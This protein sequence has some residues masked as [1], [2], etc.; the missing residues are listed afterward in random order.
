MSLLDHRLVVV[1]GKGGVGRTTLTAALA[2][3]AARAGKRTVAVELSGQRALARRLGCADGTFE[4]QRIKPRLGVMSLSPGTCLTDFGRRKLRLGGLA[5]WLFES[6]WMTGFVEAVPGLHDVVQLG[7]IEN[8]IREP[9]PGDDEVDLV[10]LDAPATGHGLTLLQS[11]RSMRQITRVGPF[12]DLAAII[13][14]FLADRTETASLLTTLPE[15]L[16]VNESLDLLEALDAEGALPS[17]VWVNRVLPPLLPGGLD[18]ERLLHTLSA[19]TTPTHEVLA[20][21]AGD[22]TRT[23]TR[24]RTAVAQLREALSARASAPTVHLLPEIRGS[25][26]GVEPLEPLVDAFLGQLD[27]GGAP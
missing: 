16:P 25:E 13:E 1:Q 26:Q 14:D 24:Q 6:R 27:V 2:L 23:R 19:G 20:A 3:A 4:A 15:L 22:H 12:H 17:S 11:A 18:Q 9:L 5:K 10:V 21:L 7:K 8:M